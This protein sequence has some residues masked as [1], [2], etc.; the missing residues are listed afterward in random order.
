MGE[1]TVVVEKYEGEKPFNV[2]GINDIGPQSI[3]RN[4]L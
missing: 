4:H 2:K 3:G 1:K